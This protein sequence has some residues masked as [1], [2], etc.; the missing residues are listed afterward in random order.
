MKRD[1]KEV[2]FSEEKIEGIVTRLAGQINS[3]Y[4]EPLTAVGILKG[5]MVFYAD[6]VRR[7]E[8]PVYFDF[9]EVSSYGR[10]TTSSGVVKINKDLCSDIEGKH[11][12]VIE[13]IVDSGQ[14]LRYLVDFLQKR[15]PKSLEVCTLLDK[16]SRRKVPFVPTFVGAEIPDEFVVGYGLD[17][18]EKY[19][20][21]PYV[22][23]LKPEVYA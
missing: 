16:P 3:Q 12:L 17:F 8:Q 5:S 23:I 20:N 4:H 10:S 9:L 18:A 13:D 14:T 15:N 21:L 1:V 6:L 2:L 11:V 22:G 19:R 7:I